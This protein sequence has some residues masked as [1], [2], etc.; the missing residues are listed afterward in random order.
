MSVRAIWVALAFA[1]AAAFCSACFP[2]FDPA[3]CYSNKDCP[4]DQRCDPVPQVCVPAPDAGEPRD[5]DSAETG[6]EDADSGA[7][8]GTRDA[9]PD[10]GAL[11][12]TWR[13]LAPN[14]APRAREGAAIS[15]SPFDRALV[16]AGGCGDD[17]LDCTETWFWS[18]DRWTEKSALAT[19]PARRDAILA[20]SD[21][22][23]LLLFGGRDPAGGSAFSDSYSW[24]G[25]TWT[26]VTQP[27]PPRA[28]FSAAAA[29]D[30][31]HRIIVMFG[32]F[33][34][35]LDQPGCVALGESCFFEN[36]AWRCT[37]LPGPSARGE[38]A[39]SFDSI[40]GRVVMFG[41]R[42]ENGLLDDAW[43]FDGAAWIELDRGPSARAGASL[44]FDAL[45]GVSVLFGGES[46]GPVLEDSTWELRERRWIPVDTSSTAPARRSA[47][48]GY[49]H[50]GN[51][52]ILFGGRG[53]SGLLGDS[54]QLVAGRR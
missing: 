37:T 14:T 8:T 27:R 25:S 50:G 22:G 11:T 17:P 33:T 4:S 16:L 39:M 20:E 49:D 51:Q 41:G 18:G 10:A 35:P 36:M 40:A 42:N 53:G 26:E 9:R 28:R 45:R 2:S 46:E 32:G 34:C 15:Y 7:D 3:G 31:L 12:G 30:P 52:L 23:P 6:G 29:Y 48:F 21:S 19:F 24:T 43:T 38:P 1:P 54:W 5:A 13:E 47:A 44:A